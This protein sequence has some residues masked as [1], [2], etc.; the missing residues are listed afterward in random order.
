MK[1]EVLPVVCIDELEDAVNRQYDVDLDLLSLLF[2]DRY[3][4][5]C[6]KRFSYDT[7]EEYKGYFWQNEQRLR[8]LAMVKT[9]LQDILPDYRAVLIDVSW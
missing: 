6:Y 2:G 1:I 9:Y 4:N 7:I 5:D 8:E 3:S